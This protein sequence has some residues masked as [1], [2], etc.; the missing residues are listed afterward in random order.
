MVPRDQEGG[1]GNKYET[2]HNTVLVGN[3]VR[4][5][6]VNFSGFSGENWCQEDLNGET[7]GSH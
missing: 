6:L 7:E 2:A 4:N 1:A 5:A 3:L